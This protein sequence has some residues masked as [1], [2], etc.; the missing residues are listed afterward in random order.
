MCREN[1]SV[2]RNPA[3]GWASL[4]ANAG[5]G[6]RDGL[7]HAGHFI[8]PQGHAVHAL[9]HAF[10]ARNFIGLE[11]DDFLHIVQKFD[12]R[13]KNVM[14]FGHDPSFTEFAAYMIHGFRQSIP[15]AGVLIMEADRAGWRSLRGGDARMVHFERPPASD[16]QKR[17]H[18][19]LDP[20]ALAIQSGILAGVRDFG[21]GD[22]REVTRLVARA[23]TRLARELGP[24]AG[25]DAHGVERKARK[26]K[27]KPRSRR[28]RA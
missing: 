15:K 16:E 3:L 10:G 2:P 17:L 26:K 12:N 18:D 21:I 7:H 5:R 19:D 9:D 25:I 11:P 6:S 22:S 1:I 14:V 28:S 27:A 23:A 13:L 20:L 24:R 8:G 4:A